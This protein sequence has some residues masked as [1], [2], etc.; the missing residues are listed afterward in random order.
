[1]KNKGIVKVG[2][3]STLVVT[4]FIGL[5]ANLQK[6]RSHTKQLDQKVSKEV[7]VEFKEGNAKEHELMLKYLLAIHGKD[8]S[9][10]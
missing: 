6:I 10:D 2:L 3:T 1:M 8:L 4:A 9:K 7:L 5:G